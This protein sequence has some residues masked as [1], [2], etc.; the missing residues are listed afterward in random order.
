MCRHLHLPLQSGSDSVL[1]RMGR[2]YRTADFRQLVDRLRATMPDVAITADVM[3]G[4]PGETDPEHRASVDFI[5]EIGFYE[6]HIFRYSARPGTSAARLPDD[7]PPEVKRRRSEDVHALNSE[8]HAAYR[9]RFL[10]QTMEVLWEEPVTPAASR[11]L[12]TWSGLTDNYLR[13]YGSGEELEGR[14]TP[15]RLNDL[16]GE[17]IG[18]EI[19]WTTASSAE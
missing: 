6:Q 16:A 7:V 5:R 13:V 12:R 3:V 8:L 4:F 2:R 9:R 10:G 11:P 14:L 19:E 15:V 1:R 17:G 18:G